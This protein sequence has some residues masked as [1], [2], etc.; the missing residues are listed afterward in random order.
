VI[1]LLVWFSTAPSSPSLVE[2]DPIPQ[3][4][5]RERSDWQQLSPIKH[6]YGVPNTAQGFLPHFIC[7]HPVNP[8]LHLISKDFSYFHASKFANLAVA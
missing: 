7:P 1:G 5:D 4:W 8:H 3:A 6:S 2:L